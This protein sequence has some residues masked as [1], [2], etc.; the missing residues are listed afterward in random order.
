ML[1]TIYAMSISRPPGEDDAD[2]NNG[3]PTEPRTK[4]T[5]EDTVRWVLGLLRARFKMTVPLAM[6]TLTHWRLAG[7]TRFETVFL[8]E[9]T[10]F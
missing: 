7:P 3:A 10:P 8:P 1:F 9:I 2:A 6:L 4:Q 5:R